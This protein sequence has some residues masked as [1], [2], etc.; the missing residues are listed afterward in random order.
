MLNGKVPY[1]GKLDKRIIIV[2]PIITD[3]DSNEDKVD[4]YEIIDTDPRPYAR[5]T[6]KVGD[7]VVEGNQVKHI[8][9]VEIELRHRTDITIKNKVVIDNEMFSVLSS[10][11]LG[12]I[13]NRFTKISGEYLKDYVIT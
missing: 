4:G 1:T 7:T 3:G 10:V 5:V 13:R 9:T 11:P 2:E 6:Y 12:E 8:R